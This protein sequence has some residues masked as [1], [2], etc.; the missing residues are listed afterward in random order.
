MIKY[1]PKFGFCYAV[2]YGPA[3]AVGTSFIG[4]Q[5]LQD[6][7]GKDVAHFRICTTGV[8]VELNAQFKVMKKLKL[9]GEPFKVHKNTAFIKGMFNSKLEVAK[10]SGAQ[11]RTVS[12]IRGQIKKAVKENAPEG[13]FRATFEDKILKSD[14]VFCKTWY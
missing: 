1:T 12:G 3:Y 8:V 5:R 2:F 7:D 4:V 10:F 13:S 14:M 9:I 6:E 11:I